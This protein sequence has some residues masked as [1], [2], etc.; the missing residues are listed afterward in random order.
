MILYK[1]QTNLYKNADHI[2]PLVGSEKIAM[3]HEDAILT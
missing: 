3:L 2:I 1:V